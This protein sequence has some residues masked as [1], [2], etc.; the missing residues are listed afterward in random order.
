[1]S[2]KTGRAGKPTLSLDFPSRRPSQSLWIKFVSSVYNNLSPAKFAKDVM[3]EELLEGFKVG[4]F[5]FL[6]TKMAF[7]VFT[8]LRMRW[9]RAILESQDI[10]LGGDGKAGVEALLFG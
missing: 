8:A 1:M 5:C 2:A 4:A 6:W 7:V 3:A 10:C 9:H